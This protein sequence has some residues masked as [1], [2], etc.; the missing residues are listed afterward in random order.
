MFETAESQN[1]G[2]ITDNSVQ[3]LDSKAL[4]KTDESKGSIDESALNI[5]IKPTSASD[6]TYITTTEPSESEIVTTKPSTTEKDDYQSL[7][8]NF[9]QMLS[10]FLN[11]NDQSVKSVNIDRNNA[12]ASAENNIGY[13]LGLD[14][15]AQNTVSNSSSSNYI[16]TVNNIAVNPTE[17]TDEVATTTTYPNSGEYSDVQTTTT[18]DNLETFLPNKLIGTSTTTEISLETEICYRGKC[19]KTKKSKAS[20]LLPVE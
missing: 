13:V 12:S 18:E 11:S 3:A 6:D 7:Q 1:L 2:R 4:P 20:D 16:S 15:N 8:N 19:V 5:K 9:A 10:D 14:P 17:I